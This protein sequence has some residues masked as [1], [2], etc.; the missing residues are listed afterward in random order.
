[1]MTTSNGKIF[2]VT[3]PLW[4]ESIGH[5]SIPSQR[6]VTRSVDVFFDPRLHKQLSKQSRRRL[7]ETPSGSLWCRCNGRL[8]WRTWYYDENG[9]WRHD[10]KRFSYACPFLRGNRRWTVVSPHTDPALRGIHAVCLNK[11]KLN[12]RVAGYLRRH[13]AYVTSVSLDV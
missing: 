1:M 2:R 10:M 8:L 13:D 5:R 7:L 4:L 6:P 3:G 11:P 9:W 12:S